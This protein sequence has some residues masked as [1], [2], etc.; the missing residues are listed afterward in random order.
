MNWTL[1]EHKIDLAYIIWYPKHTLTNSFNMV[2][3]NSN[4]Y[5]PFMYPMIVV[6]P[7]K[8]NIIWPHTSYFVTD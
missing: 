7:I 3:L 2:Q 8:T 5:W 4:V 1:T 6:W